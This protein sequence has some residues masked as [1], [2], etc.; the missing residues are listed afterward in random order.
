MHLPRAAKALYIIINHVAAVHIPPH[1]TLAGRLQGFYHDIGSFL[2]SRDS[3]S[4]D[5]KFFT[6]QD[7][8]EGESCPR[9]RETCPA[10]KII[11]PDNCRKCRRCPP[12]MKADPTFKTCIKISGGDE[13]DK[14][15]K[16]EEKE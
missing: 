9:C 5:T 6:R 16:K 13:D 12:G 8:T 10:N 11:N 7:S 4:S 15:K 3:L 2:Q 1:L 14:K